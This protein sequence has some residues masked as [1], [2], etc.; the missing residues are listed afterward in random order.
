[1]WREVEEDLTPAARLAKDA[2]RLEMA[3]SARELVT[4]G[5]ADAQR[6]IEDLR[7]QLKT[8]GALEL[9]DLVDRADPAAWW[10]D[11]LDQ[12]R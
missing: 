3:F 12:R 2:E 11:L 1:M 10:K 8:R 6:W 7:K 5:F 4:R 9:L